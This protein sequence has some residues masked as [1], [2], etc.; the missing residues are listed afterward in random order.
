MLSAIVVTSIGG[1]LLYIIGLAIAVAL[2]YF[3]LGKLNAPGWLYTALLVCGAI[4]LLLIVIDLFLTD[5]TVRV[6]R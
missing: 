1:L 2:T 4:I 6:G 5:G 3:I